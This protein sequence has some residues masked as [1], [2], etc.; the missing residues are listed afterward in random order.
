MEGVLRAAPDHGLA[1]LLFLIISLLVGTVV[2]VSV[3]TTIEFLIPGCGPASVAL[4]RSFRPGAGLPLGARGLGTTWMVGAARTIT[5]P[6]A[7]S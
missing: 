6:A 4:R 5:L 1:V 3:G 7:I 2:T